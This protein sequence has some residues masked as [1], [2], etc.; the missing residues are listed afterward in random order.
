MLW[1]N[2]WS[3]SCIYLSLTLYGLF[4]GELVCM[5]V[6]EGEINVSFYC[7]SGI[8]RSITLFLHY[9]S[10]IIDKSLSVILSQ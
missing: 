10:I 6:Y 8:N 5:C 3:F 7:H 1:G 2:L 4:D 9:H